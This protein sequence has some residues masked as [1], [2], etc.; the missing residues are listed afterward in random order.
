M[1]LA[2]ISLGSNLGDRAA[3]LQAAIEELQHTNES[4]LQAVSACHETQSVGGPTGQGAFLNAAALLETALSPQA[5]L[6]RL[7]EIEAHRG[8]TREVRWDARTLDLDLL[9]Y[10]Q[11]VLNLPVLTIPHPRMGFRRFVL[12]PAVEI[13]PEL[14]HPLFGWTVRLLWQHSNNT[15]PYLAIACS[16]RA[17]AT[18]LATRMAQRLPARL[19]SDTQQLATTDWRQPIVTVSDFWIDA[20]VVSGICTIVRPRLV[21]WLHGDADAL[22]DQIHS[23]DTGPWLRLDARDPTAAENEAIAAAQAMQ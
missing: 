14:R 3:N 4:R 15:P 10:D 23:P 13:A 8:R 20:R 16:Q 17:P 22:A 12:A 1:S 9:L 7:Q 11:L 2:L 21:L 18:Q 5:L 6:V 19:L